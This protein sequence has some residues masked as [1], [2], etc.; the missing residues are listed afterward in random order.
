MDEYDVITKGAYQNP[1][2]V[3]Q[4]GGATK[5]G[6]IEAEIHHP[7]EK[8]PLMEAWLSVQLTDG[9]K[10]R[11][12]LWTGYWMTTTAWHQIQPIEEQRTGTAMYTFKD[13]GPHYIW[14]GGVISYV[15]ESELEL[16]EEIKRKYSAGIEV[17]MKKTDGLKA[18][19]MLTKKYDGYEEW[20]E[21][22][23]WT[24]IY[25]YGWE[26]PAHTVLELI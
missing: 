18:K 6:G 21:G 16:T 13:T 17:I 12:V 20:V 2:R 22:T 1:Y 19:V 8:Y 4:T 11:A 24:S 5:A 10:A 3:I 25:P 26:K 15:G 9:L 23:G 7:K 14:K